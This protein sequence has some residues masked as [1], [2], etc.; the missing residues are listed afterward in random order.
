[1]YS[2]L[3]ICMSLITIWMLTS[4]FS[5]VWTH[6]RACKSMH[7]NLTMP[8]DVDMSVPEGQVSSWEPMSR[9]CLLNR[10]VAQCNK[11]GARRFPAQ[12]VNSGQSGDPVYQRDSKFDNLV[13]PGRY[14]VRRSRCNNLSYFQCLETPTCGWLLDRSSKTMRGRCVSGT[15]VGPLNP[16]HAPDAEDAVRNN[17]S[18]HDWQFSNPNPFII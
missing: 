2:S 15:P 4:T 7:E 5:Q 6:D 12:F 14:P 17:I 10:Y 13:V 9:S 18:L 16:V 1:M 11:P 3:I 8:G